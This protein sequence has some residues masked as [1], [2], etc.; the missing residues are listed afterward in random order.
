MDTA[1]EASPFLYLCEVYK[2]QAGAVDD[3]VCGHNM[4]L[5]KQMVIIPRVLKSAEKEPQPW[6]VKINQLT[7]QSACQSACQSIAYKTHKK[8]QKQLLMINKPIF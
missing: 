8:H 7:N 3:V 2:V 4:L 5:Q 1:Y 6:P